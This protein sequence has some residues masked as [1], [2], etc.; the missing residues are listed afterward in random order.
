MLPRKYKVWSYKFILYPRVMWPLKM[1][2]VHLSMADKMDRLANLFIRKWL[3]LPKCLSE[4]GLFGRI[5]LQLPLRSIQGY[6]L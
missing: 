6:R 2:E 5:M 1:C 3:G 4:A